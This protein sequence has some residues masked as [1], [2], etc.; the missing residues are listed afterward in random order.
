M[1][2]SNSFKTVLLLG[3]NREVVDG[4]YPVLDVIEF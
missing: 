4:E 2:Q 1:I 3:K